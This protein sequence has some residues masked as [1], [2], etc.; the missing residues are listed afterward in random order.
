MA[1]NIMAKINVAAMAAKWLKAAKRPAAA[2]INIFNNL[3]AQWR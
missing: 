1:A 3:A 2:K